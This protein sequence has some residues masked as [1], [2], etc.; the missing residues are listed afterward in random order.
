MWRDHDVDE[1]VR[2]VDGELP[3]GALAPKSGRP[4][5]TPSRTSCLATCSIS[6]AIAWHAWL[7]WRALAL[8]METWRLM[9]GDTMR[10]ALTRP[11]ASSS[12][13]ASPP[14]A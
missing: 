4:I 6:A 8:A 11:S 7:S 12:P 9:V 2:A 10:A 5:Q 1:R 3:E 14:M 13:R